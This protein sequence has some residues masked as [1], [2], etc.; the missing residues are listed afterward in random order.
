MKRLGGVTLA[1]FA[2][3]AWASVAPALY[4]KDYENAKDVS[5]ANND[6]IR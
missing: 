1:L 4:R 5:C 3:V 2:T 6:F